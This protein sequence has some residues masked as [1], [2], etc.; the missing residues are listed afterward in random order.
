MPGTIL[1]GIAVETADE[2]AAGFVEFAEPLFTQLQCHVTWFLTG[3]TLEAYP[4]IFR[5][6]EKNPFIDI[7][8]HTYSHILLKTVVWKL[9]DGVVFGNATDWI[10]KRGGSLEDIA[11]DLEKC[12][13]VFQR[14]LGRRAVALTTPWGYYRGLMDRPDILEICDR[15][16]FKIV[17]AFSRNEHDG[18]PIPFE[19]QP[20]FYEPQGFGH[21][22]ETM[23]H[24]FQD[25]YAWRHVARPP[26]GASYLEYLKTCVDR[27]A[28]EDLVW[29]VCSHDHGAAAQARAQE[30]AEWY[31]GLIEYG[32]EKGC[33]FLTA[34]R[35]YQ[36][37]IAGKTEK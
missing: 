30:K 18:E 29:G 15:L 19:W 25:D 1:I 9:P 26:E 37:M 20:F 12:Q 17:R 13:Q 7:Q 35:F 14:V 3:R 11:A 23:V 2:N 36:E 5:R 10:F 24:G 4:D 32:R 28:A 21:I 22:L 16:G 27:V 31:R 33:R 8:S 6:I 34:V